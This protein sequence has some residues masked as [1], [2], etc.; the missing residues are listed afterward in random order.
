MPYEKA[1]GDAEIDDVMNKAAEVHENGTRWP[2][3]SYEEGVENA[4]RWVFGATDDN[5]MED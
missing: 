3:Q 2:G 5:P 4:L 1:R